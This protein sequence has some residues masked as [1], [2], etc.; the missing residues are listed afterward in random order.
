MLKF[1]EKI[2]MQKRELDRVLDCLKRRLLSAHFSPRQFRHDIEVMLVRFRAGEHLER[3]AVVWI[4]TH[5][6]PRFQ[7]RCCEIGR[8]LEH[9]RLQSVLGTDPQSIVTQDFGD[10]RYRTRRFE[11]EIADNDVG[12]VD[13]HARPVFQFRERDARIDIA[14]IIGPAHDDVGGVA[15]RRAEKCADAIRGRS[16]FLDDFLQLLDHPARLDDCFFVL[17]DLGPQIEQLAPNRI[18]WRQRGN[19]AIKRI[20][21]ITC[22]RVFFP[23]LESFAALVAHLWFG[24]IRRTDVI[25]TLSCALRNACSRMLSE[26]VAS[27]PQNI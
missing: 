7:C 5:F 25:I 13:E 6:V 16:H 17:R 8:A 21:K 1:F 24:S 19:D 27:S 11:S 23:A 22:P 4:D 20:E 14:I 10:F 12:F 2:D 26:F 15:R 18:A 9:H 3:H